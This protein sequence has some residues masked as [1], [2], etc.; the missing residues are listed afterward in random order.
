MDGARYV[1]DGDLNIG[2]IIPIHDYDELRPCGAH[3]RE[4]GVVQNAEALVYAVNRINANRSILPGIRLGV[5]VLDDCSKDLTALRQA[6]HFL[7]VSSRSSPCQD[8]CRD[9]DYNFRFYDIIG[10]IGSESTRSTIM[11][12]NILGMFEIPQISPLATSDLLSDK[13]RFPYFLRTVPPDRY[14]VLAMLSVI[15]HF[16]WTYVSAV[17]SE[18]GYGENALEEFTRQASRLGICVGVSLAA[19][20]GAPAGVFRDIV[21]SL[22]ES[23][24]RVVLL[25]TDLEETRGVFTAV[26]NAGLLGRFVWLGSDGIAFNLDNLHEFQDVAAGTLTFKS[27]SNPL[28]EFDSYFQSL[29]P[30]RSD[31][32]W[33]EPLWPE[34]FNC[35]RTGNPD[36]VG[37]RRVGDSPNYT[38]E[39]KVSLI[40][41]AVNVLATSLHQLIQT[42]CSWAFNQNP[43]N[44]KELRRCVRGNV[45]LEYLKAARVNGINGLIE[46]DQHLDVL[47]TYE[48]LNIQKTP[49]AGL[50]AVRVALWDVK[51]R[52]MTTVEENIRW[53]LADS[54]DNG[55]ASPKS[56]CGE[57]CKLHEIYS[58]FKDSC[59]WE[60][61]ACNSNEVTASNRTKCQTCPRY[62]WPD[63]ENFTL[64]LP[65][66]PNYVSW[67]D[68]AVIVFVIL[69]IL[70]FLYCSVIFAVYVTHN[71][72]R[73]IKA[74]SRE[75]SYMLLGGVSIQYVMLFTVVSPPSAFV[76]CFN[77]VGFNVSFTV[78]YSAILTRTNRIY[79]IFHAGKRTK[80]MPRFISSVSQIVITIL[81]IL[82]QVRCQYCYGGY[83]A[84]WFFWLRLPEQMRGG[85]RKVK[86]FIIKNNS[87]M[88][89][90]KYTRIWWRIQ[91]PQ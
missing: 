76:C 56:H 37:D 53:N 27:L 85:R 59:C 57:T 29:S 91:K 16:N 80:K 88:A 79:R 34:L 72:V 66:P 36:C 7:P 63:P 47:G 73:L 25:F 55:S 30:E 83:L 5:V 14:Q 11:I 54:T 69:S 28:P 60:C 43:L 2:A 3:L 17:C 6:L 32:P 74:T 10:V 51:S 40:V 42:N 22:Y 8:D 31:N 82:I 71:N 48:V 52:N 90:T 23:K 68:S 19:S 35:S 13:K 1:V 50:R 26:R 81:L 38:P 89:I 4:P 77:F 64:C 21:T 86:L 12:A 15:Q 67:S 87:W 41:D 78:V 45:L 44:K 20:Q 33:L 75:L 65:L 39:A 18:G 70:G 9:Q 61:R 46:F 62:T 49:D 58:F 24:A 84:P